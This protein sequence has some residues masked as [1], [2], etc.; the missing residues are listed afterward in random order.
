MLLMFGLNGA[1]TGMA[2]YPTFGGTRLTAAVRFC[3]LSLKYCSF[4]Y[5]YFNLVSWSFVLF[6]FV[7]FRTFSSRLTCRPVPRCARCCTLV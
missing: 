7:S 3:I 5:V 6:R 2:L 1:L 4:S